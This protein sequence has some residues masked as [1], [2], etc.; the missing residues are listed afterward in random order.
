LA[1]ALNAGFE[2]GPP[3][4]GP[5]IYR[6]YLNERLR[7]SEEDLI[8]RG[9]LPAVGARVVARRRWP[10]HGP[11]RSWRCRAAL[12]TECLP[13]GAPKVLA[14]VLTARWATLAAVGG[15]WTGRL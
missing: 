15:C 1:E 3:L 13:A 7:P 14:F 11:R 9:E 5:Y 2:V 6:W 4:R 10:D 12:P 8:A